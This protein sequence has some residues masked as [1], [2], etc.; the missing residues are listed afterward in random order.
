VTDALSRTTSFQYDTS[1]RLTRTTY[2][3][4]NY[5][6]LTYDARGNVTETRAVGKSGS[7]ATDIVATASYPS[8]CSNLLT[9]NKPASTTDARGFTTDYAY[10]STHG[11]VTSVTLPA[12][13]SATGAVRPQT[14][15][16]YTLTSGVYALTSVSACQTTSSCTGGADEAKTTIAYN[17]NLLPQTVT[18]GNGSGTLAAAVTNAYDPIGNLTSVDGPLS[19]TA[20][21]VRYRYNSARQLVGTISADPD[22][23]GALKH[24]A[25]RNSYNSERILTKVEGGTVNSQSDSD[26]AAMSVLDTVD[27]T[28]DSNRRK[29]KQTLTSASAVQSAVQFS[30]DALGRPDCTAVRMNSAVFGSLP[31]SACSLGTQGSHGPDR[32]TK[33][34]Y[35]AAGQVTQSKSAVG[36]A[37]EAADITSTYSSNGLVATVTDAENNKTTYEYDGHDRLVK[38]RFPDATK[39]AGTSSATDYEQRTLD[40]AGNATGRRLRDAT[41]IGYTYDTLGRV[42]LK[43]LPGTELDVSYTYDALSRMTGASQSGHAL[44]YTYDALGRQLTEV[45]PQGTVTSTYDLAGRRTRITH[46]GG[47]FYVDQDYLVTGELWKVRENGATTGVGVLATYAWDD[48]GRRTSLT[49]GNGTATTYGYDAASRLSSLAEDVGGTSYDQTLGFTYTLSGQIATNSR[50]NDLYAWNGHYNINRGYTAN[51]LNQYSAAGSVSFG[52]D[53]RGNLTTSGT[54]TYGYTS[55]NQLKSGPGTTLAYDPAMRLYQT[56]GAS[57]TRFGYDGVNLVG[58]YNGS[59]TLLRRYVHGASMDEPLVWYE[60]SGTTDRRFLHTDERGSVIATSNGSGTVTATNAYDEYGIPKSTNTGRFQYTGQTWLPE[61]GLYYYKA[62]IYSPTLGRF[63]QTDPIGYGDGMNMY[64]YVGGDPVNGTDPSGTSRIREWEEEKARRDLEKIIEKMGYDTSGMSRSEQYEFAGEL[65]GILEDRLLAQI[66]AVLD[67][68]GQYIEAVKNASPDDVSIAAMA[69]EAAQR[70]TGC[71]AGH[72]GNAPPNSNDRL[73]IKQLWADPRIRADMRS[74]W[75]R[76]NPYGSDRNEHGFWISRTR[77]GGFISHGVY[78]GSGDSIQAIRWRPFGADIF[79]H[80][81]PFIE[82]PWRISTRDQ[83]VAAYGVLVIAYAHGGNFYT[84]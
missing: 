39:G 66:Q 19:G 65:I 36:T 7:G 27:I 78:A 16:G 21:T 10:D 5:V 51:G 46:P 61:L 33:T 62:R 60:G 57:T 83:R 2:P 13:S 6:Q 63:L 8:T 37:L 34:V 77:N 23:A 20:D 44:S 58:E 9:C 74:A 1:G 48:R 80:T 50:S 42:T 40:A 47:G 55:E 30:Y 18:S 70:G 75:Q 69:A 59:N 72:C 32:I 28:L 56:V 71:V 14:R 67:E 35:D 12:P 52:Y 25:T 82:L 45:G 15:Y 3:E 54:T 84:Y 38:T 11:Q 76:S 22:G 31:S 29:V 43:D 41:S 4:G 64:A 17:S 53:G 81:H 24:R 49:R 79:F 73:I 26:W 68:T